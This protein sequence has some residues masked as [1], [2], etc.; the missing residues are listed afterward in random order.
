MLLVVS[1]LVIYGGVFLFITMLTLFWLVMFL[2]MLV[3]VVFPGW[4]LRWCLLRIHLRPNAL[5]S[6]SSL[7]PLHP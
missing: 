4:S 1:V 5:P 7:P 6:S 3:Q 2:G